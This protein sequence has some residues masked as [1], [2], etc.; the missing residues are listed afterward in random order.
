[1]VGIYLRIFSF[2]LLLLIVFLNQDPFFALLGIAVSSMIML[3]WPDSRMRKGLFFIV[4]LTGGTFVGNLFSL[5]GRV[6]VHNGLFT[7][8]EES[9]KAA[10]VRASRVAVLMVGAKVLF[11]GP[12]K[13]GPLAGMERFLFALRRLLGP[14]ERLR[15]PVNDFFEIT[16]QTLRMV[17]LLT[18]SIKKETEGVKRPWRLTKYI[19]RLFITELKADRKV[20]QR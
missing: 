8:T 7:I 6:L 3:F 1:M 11:L 18:E 5:P 13:G 17:P 20:R 19:Y 15:I 10:L 4:L 2:L 9:L 14:L 16:G 12:L